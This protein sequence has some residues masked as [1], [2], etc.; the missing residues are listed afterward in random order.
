MR[1]KR[2][3]C[4]YRYFRKHNRRFMDKLWHWKSD[5]KCYIFKHRLFAKY[6]S[7]AKDTML[8]T[9]GLAPVVLAGSDI[10]ICASVDSIQ[11]NASVSGGTTTG[12]WTTNGTGIFYPDAQTLDAQYILSAYDSSQTYISLV[13]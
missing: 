1:G 2:Y 4:P 13:L 9:F 5:T 12:Q 11:L 10:N 8:I 6:C 7:T 3:N